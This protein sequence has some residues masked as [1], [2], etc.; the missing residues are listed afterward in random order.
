MKIVKIFI[1]LIIVIPVVFVSA[2]LGGPFYA[3]CCW[4]GEREVVEP[5]L[6]RVGERLKTLALTLPAINC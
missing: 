1:L 5:M 4:A 6:D 3:L 2:V